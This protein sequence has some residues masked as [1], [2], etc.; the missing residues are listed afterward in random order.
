M[1]Q[2]LTIELY[3][4]AEDQWNTPV[5][6][7]LVDMETIKRKSAIPLTIMGSLIIC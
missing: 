5:Y 3:M 6:V 2:I 1:E 4:S 7:L